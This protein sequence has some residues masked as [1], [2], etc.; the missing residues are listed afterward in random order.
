MVVGERDLVRGE[1]AAD[2]IEESGSGV[3]H[4]LVC[5]ARAKLADVKLL[6]LLGGFVGFDIPKEADIGLMTLLS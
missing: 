2:G 6:W 5:F 3:C 4:F 1:F